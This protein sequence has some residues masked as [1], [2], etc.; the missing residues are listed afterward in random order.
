MLKSSTKENPT[1]EK[2]T[3]K[4]KVLFNPKDKEKLSSRL[5]RA[6]YKMFKK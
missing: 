5:V 3:I 4:K 1:N 2:Q 6:F